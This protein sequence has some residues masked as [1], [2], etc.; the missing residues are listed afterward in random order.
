MIV[1]LKELILRVYELFL[2][3]IS[4]KGLIFMTA[5]SLLFLGKIDAFI[6][7]F[8]AA[9]FVGIRTLEKFLNLKKGL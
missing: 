7:G 5:T 9:G 1:K 4:V 6:W 2:K 3:L 8:F